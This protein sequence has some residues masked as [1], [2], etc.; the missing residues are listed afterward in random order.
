MTVLDDR[1][2]EPSVGGDGRAELPNKGDQR[3][4]ECIVP[5]AP[6]VYVSF[7]SV[8]GSLAQF[9]ALYPAVLDVLADLQI[10]VLVTTG[11]GFDPA[12]LDPLPPNAWA[13]Q[14][15]PQEAAM[16]EA[17]LVIGH[18]GFGTTMAALRAG[19]PQ[20]VVPLFSSDQ[21]LNGERVEAVGAGVQLLG[22]LAGLDQVPD[23]VTRLLH[24]PRFTDAARVVAAEMAALPDLD[25]C[26][27]VLQ[28]LAR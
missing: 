22:G 5:T 27:M 23:A 19:V 24:Q 13:A 9:G 7:G 2:V 28:D 14:W 10:R 8:A 4:T 21:F 6:L 12:Q 18:G 15:W 3:R 11:T 25:Q 1:Q 16:T 17:A 26:V 20:I